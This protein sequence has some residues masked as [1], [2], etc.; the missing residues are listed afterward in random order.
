MKWLLVVLVVLLI[1][2]GFLVSNGRALPE[3][4]AQ[5]GEPCSSCHVSPS[6]GGP[7][8]PRGQAWVA[9]GK[10]GQVPDLVSSLELLGV[11]IEV[12]QS[13]F[14]TVP[15]TIAPAQPLTTTP[16]QNKRIHQW[17]QSYPGN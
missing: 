17:L 12:D 6:G 3:Y 11:H 10:P 9:G 13:E 14:T 7:R 2:G 4:A 15:E 5:T 16:G 8:G 1:L